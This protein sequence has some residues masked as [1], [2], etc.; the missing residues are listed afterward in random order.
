MERTMAWL[1]GC[2]RLH[3]R[4]YLPEQSWCA[5]P[6]RRQAAGIPEEIEFATKPRLA[7]EMIAA[8]LDAGVE[9]PWVTGDEA[10]GQVRG[11]VPPWRHAGRAT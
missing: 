5:D 1:V 2:R 9:A 3:R 4:L 6:E 8:A 10:Y 11:C 7:W